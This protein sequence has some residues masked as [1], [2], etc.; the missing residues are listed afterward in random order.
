MIR[1]PHEQ[2]L[3]KQPL[4]NKTINR[5]AMIQEITNKITYQTIRASGKNA[6]KREHRLKFVNKHINCQRKRIGVY[7]SCIKGYTQEELANYLETLNELLHVPMA[8][9]AVMCQVNDQLPSNNQ[10]RL[11]A[12]VADGITLGKIPRCPKCEH[13]RL[14]FNADSGVYTCLGY[15]KGKEFVECKKKFEKKEI[16]RTEW[17]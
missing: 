6:G 14:S 16:T 4:F 17:L 3:P 12:Q 2:Y 8:E 15:V 11:A 10:Y 9:L 7:D 13:G 5:K 1:T